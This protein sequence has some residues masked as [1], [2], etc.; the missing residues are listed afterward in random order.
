MFS[1][2]NRIA[3]LT[4]KLGAEELGAVLTVGLPLFAQAWEER[5][6]FRPSLCSCSFLH[7]PHIIFSNRA[8]SSS[9]DNDVYSRAR[10]TSL[11]CSIS[12]PVTGTIIASTPPRTKTPA[13]P[14]H[15]S[16]YGSRKGRSGRPRQFRRVWLPV[17]DMIYLTTDH[18]EACSSSG[19][20]SSPNLR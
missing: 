4:R 2:A 16:N 15:V 3:V 8:L 1:G 18:H 12:K 9:F 7:L 17:H 11:L 13:I 5:V 6:G 19:L 14:R 10:R 20:S